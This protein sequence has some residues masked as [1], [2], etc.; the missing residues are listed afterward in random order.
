VASGIRQVLTGRLPEQREI[1]ARTATT[2]LMW[3]RMREAIRSAVADKPDVIVMDLRMPDLDGAAATAEIGRVAPDVA[4]LVLTMF[5]DDESVF[6]AMRAGAR[7]YVVKGA[8]QQ[9]IIRAI[10]AVAA[11]ETKPRL[12]TRAAGSLTPWSAFRR[13]HHKSDPARCTPGAGDHR[14]A[15]ASRCASLTPLSGISPR[16]AATASVSP[17]G[18]YVWLKPGEWVTTASAGYPEAVGSPPPGLVAALR[19]AQ[20]VVDGRLRVFTNPHEVWAELLTAPDGRAPFWSY[21]Q[22]PASV[23]G[24]VAVPA[25]GTD[26][27]MVAAKWSNG[28]L[29][30]IDA[31]T[32]RVA[33]RTTVEL[34]IGDD[35]NSGGPTGVLTIYGDALLSLFTAETQHQRATVIS[36][37]EQSADAFEPVGA[38]GAESG[39]PGPPGPPTQPTARHATVP[40]PGRR[41]ATANSRISPSGSV[42]AK[43]DNTLTRS[44]PASLDRSSAIHAHASNVADQRTSRD[45][46]RMRRA[47]VSAISL[48]LPAQLE[49]ASGTTK[50]TAGSRLALNSVKM[51]RASVEREY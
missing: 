20:L 2:R 43:P 7:G 42:A 4:V 23:V 46:S 29:V 48:K 51:G 37:G 21:H 13:L 6:A 26:P 18:G 39:L 40:S 16:L 9:E 45:G 19:A 3:S 50:R 31:R 12:K 15:L 24:V 22:F 35:Y 44:R 27:P 36:S 28:N 8:S 11:G 1:D 41:Q 17:R 34:G 25:H 14:R 10:N 30:G 38:A 5:D 49:S 47:R 33:W 32:G